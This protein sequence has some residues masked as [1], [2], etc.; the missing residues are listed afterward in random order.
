MKFYTAHSTIIILASYIILS[1]A[2][3]AMV[4]PSDKSGNFYKWFF[5]FSHGVL[6]QAGRFFN[7]GANGNAIQNV[8]NVDNPGVK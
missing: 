6:L 4:P 5:N 3:N 1:N 8:V 2:V 7:K